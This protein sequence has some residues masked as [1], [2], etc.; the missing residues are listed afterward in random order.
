MV[1]RNTVR[2]G[3]W[4]V[5]PVILTLM[6][7]AAWC[8]TI[9]V[10]DSLEDVDGNSHMGGTYPD[11]MRY[12][13]VYDASQ[14]TALSGSDWIT[15]VHL[16]P[17]QDNGEPFASTMDI[18]F[19]LSTTS[20]GPDS[21]S[22]TFADN[23]GPDETVV[24]S[25]QWVLSSSDTGPGPRDFDIELALTTPFAYDPSV[26]NLL[27]DVFL[28]SAFDCTD[29]DAEATAGDSV[30]AVQNS[31]IFSPTGQIATNGLVTQF[32]IVPEPSGAVVLGAGIICLALLR[33][34]RQ[35]GQ[36][37]IPR[38]AAAPVYQNRTRYS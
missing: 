2:Y 5:A 9:V 23:I 38:Y 1:K 26:G 17:D 21:L 12:Q 7:S 33:R 36:S 20:A 16:R 27:I 3:T 32:T 28:Y 29:I 13:Q 14:F 15:H 11:G 22:T 6:A 18:E 8:F 31:D 35:Q 4:F 34:L 10:P 19:R 24:F 30:S 25:G 37:S